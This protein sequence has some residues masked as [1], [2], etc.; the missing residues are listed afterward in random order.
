MGLVGIKS[1]VLAVVGAGVLVGVDSCVLLI[2][3]AVDAVH[4]ETH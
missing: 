1:V 3:G 4:A 2:G